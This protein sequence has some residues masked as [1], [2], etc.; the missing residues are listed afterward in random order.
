[1]RCDVHSKLDCEHFHSENIRRSSP[2]ALA[3]MKTKKKTMPLDLHTRAQPPRVNGTYANPRIPPRN[4]HPLGYWGLLRGHSGVELAS[5]WTVFPLV[6]R[7]LIRGFLPSSCRSGVFVCYGGGE[8]P[9]Y[10]ECV[11]E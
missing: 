1:M 7:G 2:A 5:A 4:R 10:D 9:V 6:G 8:V 3:C 11:V